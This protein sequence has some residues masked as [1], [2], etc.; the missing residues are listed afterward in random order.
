MNFIIFS[1][2]KLLW[3]SCWMFLL[4]AFDV[5]LDV[6][7]WLQFRLTISQV[8]KLKLILNIRNTH[9][10]WKNVSTNKLTWWSF[11]GVMLDVR[12][13]QRNISEDLIDY[14][15][16]LAM[17]DKT[18]TKMATLAVSRKLNINLVY[19][20]VKKKIWRVLWKI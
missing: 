20:H 18:R 7:V 3:K 11:R 5:F 16:G 4:R 8:I 19:V 15:C 9:T 13:F 17:I 6:R 14:G 2:A 12:K 10:V 1:L